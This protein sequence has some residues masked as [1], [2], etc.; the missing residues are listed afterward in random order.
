MIPPIASAAVLMPQAFT[1]HSAMEQCP[2]RRARGMP[3]LGLEPVMSQCEDAEVTPSLPP[4]PPPLLLLPQ[5]S[6]L[7]TSPW[8]LPGLRQ[9]PTGDAFAWPQQLKRWR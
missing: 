1:I 6:P 9:R 3:H 5:S 2:A 8:T 7:Y 4:P